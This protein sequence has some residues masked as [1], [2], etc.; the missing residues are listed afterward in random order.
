[1]PKV[2]LSLT[3]SITFPRRTHLHRT[4]QH[5]TPLLLTHPFLT[6]PF[7]IRLLQLLTVTPLH[8]HLMAPSHFS[9]RLHQ[10][11]APFHHHH[12]LPTDLLQPMDL[13]Q[14][15]DLLRQL[16]DLQPARSATPD[17]GV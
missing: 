10:P 16:T 11:T 4:L 6:A 14:L 3:G 17:P 1:M 12:H 5:L 8:L 7:P 15:M 2:S 13:H 9:P